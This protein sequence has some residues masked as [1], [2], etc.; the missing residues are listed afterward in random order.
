MFR[1]GGL[2]CLFLVT[3]LA[4]H[5]H[6]AKIERCRIYREQWLTSILSF[7]GAVRYGAVPLGQ[8]FQELSRGAAKESPVD[9]FFIQMEMS[10]REIQLREHVAN[11]SFFLIWKE[12]LKLLSPLK[13]NEADLIQLGLHLGNC[14]L[15]TQNKHLQ[16]YRE[17]LERQIGAEDAEL[18]RKQTLVQA[19]YM[20]LGLVLVLVLI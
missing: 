20:A 2:A 1:V 13:L 4:G 6:A 9:A 16:R 15:Q 12:Q 11:N 3:L 19:L 8:V 5:E 18:K 10:L 17:Q 7:E 14:D